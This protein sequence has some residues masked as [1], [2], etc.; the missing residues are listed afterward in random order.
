LILV[1]IEPKLIKLSGKKTASQVTPRDLTGSYL[2]SKN[3]LTDLKEQKAVRD[4]E[5]EKDSKEA[6]NKMERVRNM[7]V[8][9]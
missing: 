5:R 4:T 8:G 2:E 6:T 3:K 7:Y 1:S 9:Y